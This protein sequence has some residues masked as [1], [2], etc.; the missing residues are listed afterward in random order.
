[1]KSETDAEQLP[2]QMAAERK[3]TIEQLLRQI[4]AED[5]GMGILRTELRQT[6]TEATL[7]WRA[8]L[9]VFLMRPFRSLN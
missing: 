8:D 1:M 5:E 4:A 3:E 2:E 9:S 7:N 6:L